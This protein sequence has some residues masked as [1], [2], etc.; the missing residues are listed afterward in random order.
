MT[1]QPLRSPGRPTLDAVAARAGVGRGTA[2]RVLNGSSQVS[3]QAKAAV[4]AA[5]VELG[6]VPNRAAR[7]LVTQRTDSVALVV[8]ESQE[9]LFGEPFFA[10]VLR[11]INAALLETPLQLWLAMAAS[12]EQRERVVNHLTGHHVDGVLLLS[13]HDEDPLP[14]ILRE[15]GMPFVLGGRPAEPGPDDFLVDVDNVAGARM[16]VEFLHENGA[17]KVAT[18]A[19]PQDMTAGH[20]RLAGYRAAVRNEALIE[21]GD[22]SEDG[23]AGAMKAL[24]ARA[25]DLDAVFAASD[26]MAS[27]ALRALRDADRRVPQDVALVGFEDAPVARQTQPPLTT[28]HQP[29][30][31]MGRRMAELLVS[32]IRR[33]PVENSHVLLDTHL[34]RRG[35]A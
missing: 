13:L 33:E 10:G 25:P 16:A 9:R 27:G 1:R 24:L 22:F 15:R 32:L 21:Y 26:L 29:V 7:Q 19:G 23:G 11:G 34:V 35:S 4:E 12:P 20:G 28:V 18:V 17:R 3:P 5:I 8:S 14:A 30:E 31:E 6:Y 2:S